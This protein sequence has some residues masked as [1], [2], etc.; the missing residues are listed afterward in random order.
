MPLDDYVSRIGCETCGGKIRCVCHELRDCAVCEQP[1]NRQD[2]V[3]CNEMYFCPECV[4]R[5][6]EREE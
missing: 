2:M 3:E 1:W 4:E 5:W 6:E